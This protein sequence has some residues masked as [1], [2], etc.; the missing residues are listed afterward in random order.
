MFKCCEQLG[1]EYFQGYFF[2]EPQ[3]LTSKTIE[4]QYAALIRLYNML[5]SGKDIKEIEAV[6]KKF[7]DP[8]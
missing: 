3:I 4:P 6:F 7:S 2:Q 5:S 1:F 8:L